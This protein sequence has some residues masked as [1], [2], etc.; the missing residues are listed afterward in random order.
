VGQTG[1]SALI[2]NP[3]RPDDMRSVSDFDL[4]HIVN[5][6]WIWD[7]PVG[8]GR[9][10]GGGL[11]GW[12]E[13][14]LGGWKIAGVLRWNSGL[15]TGRTVDL[16]GFAT[17]WQV[18]SAAVRLRDIEASPTKAGMDPN[19]FSDPVYAYQSFR[20]PLA[21]ETGDRNTWRLEPYMALDLALHKQ[22]VHH[23]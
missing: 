10:L 12:S 18:R 7:M 11:H 22:F 17:N 4:T 21:G 2:I 5:A 15:P 9:A 19:L 14:V 23:D 3:L 16:S 1:S 13:A 8:R 20:T 6:N